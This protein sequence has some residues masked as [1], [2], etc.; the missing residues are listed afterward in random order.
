MALLGFV[1]AS[2]VPVNDNTDAA[3]AENGPPVWKTSGP[4][5]WKESEIAER[6]P[7]V[8]KA[9]GPPVWKEGEVA[10]RGPPVWRKGDVDAVPAL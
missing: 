7:P 4:P 8:W 3:N 5:V 9:S 2:P 1:A 10:E 6:G